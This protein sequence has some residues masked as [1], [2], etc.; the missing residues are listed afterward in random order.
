MKY[1]LTILALTL[2]TSVSNSQ[3]DPKWVSD[4]GYWVVES[5]NKA[6]LN[7]LVY[8]YTNEGTLV[9]KESLEK[10]R[11]PL[12]KKK[13]KLRLKKALETSILAWQQKRTVEENK[14][15]VMA[16]LN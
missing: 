11:L 3:Q 5:N 10:V 1:Y 6:P 8:F 12:H 13:I 4:K 2:L 7:H 14:A 9:Y 15:Y 16:I